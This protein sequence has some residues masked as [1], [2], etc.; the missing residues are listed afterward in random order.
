MKR[1]GSH[2]HILRLYEVMQSERHVMLVTEFCAGGEIF[3][4]LVA[5]GRMTEQIARNYFDQIIDAVDFLHQNGIVH[6]D[7]KA[8]NLLLSADLK[9]VKLAD[10]GFSNYYSREALLS[11][12]CGSPPY[13]APELF[14]GRHYCGPKADVWS[15]GVVLY[16]LV[17]GALPFDGHT[18]QSLKSR[19]LSGKFRIPYFMSCDCEHLIRHMLITDPDKRFSLQQI[20]VHKWMRL[21]NINSINNKDCEQT[22]ETIDTTIDDTIDMSIIDW[23]SRE[24]SIDSLEVLESVRSR[25]YD[26]YYALYHLVNDSSHATPSSAPPSPPLLPVIPSTNQRKSSITTGI[27]ERETPSTP[28]LSAG[29]GPSPHRRHTFGPD[30]HNNA[31]SSQ[32]QLVAPPLLFLTPPSAPPP[33]ASLPLAPPNYPINNMDL[34]RPPP[35]LLMVNN[36]MGRRASDGQ[37]NYARTSAE[38]S[39]QS[40]V[41]TCS[42]S[43][44][45]FPPNSSQ[46]TSPPISYYRR[47]RHSLT[48]TNDLV[49]RQRRSGLSNITSPNNERYLLLF[50]RKNNH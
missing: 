18:L 1:V 44:F 46:Q 35:V 16:V 13:A 48:D 43:A 22:I 32:T 34:L 6:R 11:T 2:K 23:V 31:T 21:S 28:L 8:E 49:T 29:T 7:L 10:F 41:T 9:C 42:A 37:A 27:V 50:I 38:Q 39:T 40:T 24:L 5:N 14:E 12:W 36:N 19:V 33:L 3:D 30:T 17:C 15:L 47:K 45:N 26:H 20:K 25:A 4:Q